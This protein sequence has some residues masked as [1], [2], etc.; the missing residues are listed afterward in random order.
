M[1]LPP[2]IIRL[3]LYG[4]SE[5]DLVHLLQHPPNY[6]WFAVAVSIYY[7]QLKFIQFKQLGACHNLFQQ[8]QRQRKK[9]MDGFY[10]SF[11]YGQF[12]QVL[13][14][15][16][17]PEK[18]DIHQKMILQLAMD[19]S[20]LKILNLHNCFLLDNPTLTTILIH[21]PQLEKL[22]LEGCDAI[23]IDSF[24]NK[25]IQSSQS[26]L[27]R[28]SSLNVSYIPHFFST[29]TQASSYALS[30]PS[31]KELKLGH[32]DSD[33]SSIGFQCF[34]KACSPSIKKLWLQSMD[35][36]WIIICLQYVTTTFNLDSI[37][38]YNCSLNDSSLYLLLPQKKLT[39][40]TLQHCKYK[41]IPLSNKKQQQS[42]HPLLALT[43]NHIQEL[44]FMDT[45]IPLDILSSILAKIPDHQLTSFLGP[46]VDE[47]IFQK[48]IIKIKD[49]S[50]T[51]LAF[52][53]NITMDAIINQ[54]CPA[55]PMPNWLSA[56]TWLEVQFPA[57][58]P[59]PKKQ[60]EWDDFF[61]ASASLPSSSPN[62][63]SYPSYPLKVL[64]LKN[65]PCQ[66]SLNHFEIIVNYFPSLCY[67]TCQL[68][69]SIE[70]H[71]L[72]Q[73][74]DQYWPILRGLEIE[75]WDE[76]SWEEGYKGY[77]SWRWYLEGYRLNN[78]NDLSYPTDFVI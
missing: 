59:V 43:Y 10:S 75:N 73:F 48:L 50:F 51:H 74:I 60:Y 31:L 46:T 49:K 15:S 54:L 66:F 8:T 3:I 14:L 55:F 11:H 40:I 57:L 41:A 18:Y 56:L 34:M 9:K 58:P 28:L 63:H 30:L 32:V 77:S 76:I 5:K 6:D 17:I 69:P 16:L 65:G 68:N 78:I 2:E 62:H 47:S 52:N 33:S 71:H 25:K 45:R 44:N 36:E 22:S 20:N 12:V 23:Y 19:C 1:F 53:T 37:S 26:A 42:F 35:S 70:S 13:D 24:L 72:K 39:S 64:K 61:L 38:F 21:L 27:Q 67:I 7:R 29:R 4:L